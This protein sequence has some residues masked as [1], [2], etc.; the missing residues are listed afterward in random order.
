[1]RPNGHTG[2]VVGMRFDIRAA[3]RG[4]AAGRRQNVPCS[5][6]PNLRYRP[7]GVAW[8][9]GEAEAR[10]GP[11]A[12]WQVPSIQPDRQHR[13]AHTPTR[14]WVL[15]TR[16]NLLKI[17]RTVQVGIV[18]AS[19]V[20]GPSHQLREHLGQVVQHLLRKFA[21]RAAIESAAPDRATELGAD[22]ETEAARPARR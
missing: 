4:N 22:G 8:W 16:P 19:Q 11:V 14:A 2:T 17:E 1:M 15:G 3:A 13:G 18:G 7:A 10:D 9:G 6:T 20:G 5:R 12:T 21:G